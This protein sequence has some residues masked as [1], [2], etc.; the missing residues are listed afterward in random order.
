MCMNSPA[1]S[2]AV[3]APAFARPPVKA[4]ARGRRTGCGQVGDP[5]CPGHPDGT[6][7]Q[8]ADGVAFPNGTAVTADNQTLI[9]AD[10]YANQLMAFDIAGD[11]GLSSGGYGPT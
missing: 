5:S 8:V 2:A 4:R 1:A 6:A 11:G 9:L 7:R 3:M 10:S